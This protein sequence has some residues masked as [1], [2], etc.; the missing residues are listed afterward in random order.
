VE[1]QRSCL[2]ACLPVRL[3]SLPDTHSS[4]PAGASLR[5]IDSFGSRLRYAGND[6]SEPC[7]SPGR[8]RNCDCGHSARSLAADA[9]A[10]NSA[11]ENGIAP[12]GFAVVAVRYALVRDSAADL[13]ADRIASHA[14][15]A[16][17]SAAADAVVKDGLAAPAGRVVADCSGPAAAAR[18][19]ADCSG[20]AAAARVV[21][22]QAYFAFRPAAPVVVGKSGGS[23]KQEQNYSADNLGSFHGCCLYCKP[24]CSKED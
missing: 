24:R 9:S 8:R 3:G 14:A 12:Y 5:R 7:S 20:L 21:A 4:R 6:S 19:V 11:P 18:V 16:A 2:S 1:A 15:A 17:Q 23:E 13:N 22:F 10:R